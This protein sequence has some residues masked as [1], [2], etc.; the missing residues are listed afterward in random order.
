M[1]EEEFSQKTCLYHLSTDFLGV[2][3]E[4]LARNDM[5]RPL[6]LLLLHAK[7]IKAG[8][9]GRQHGDVSTPPASVYQQF[10]YVYYYISLS[11]KKPAMP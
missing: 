1:F 9:E 10:Y 4:V 3:I 2:R 11:L 7:G 6:C 5:A 8:A